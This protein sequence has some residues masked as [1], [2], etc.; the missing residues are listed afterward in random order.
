MYV[1]IGQGA[2]G[3]SAAMELR[4]L[5]RQAPVTLISAENR[6]FY[7]RIDLPDIVAG[8][9]PP[10]EALLRS[11]EQF[12]QQGVT[13]LTGQTVV[14]LLPRERRVKLACGRSLS[15]G[16]LLLALG[17]SPLLPPLPGIGAR[18]VC[19]LWT[20]EQA[21]TVLSLTADAQSAVVI[22][23]GLIGLKTAL[24]LAG[25]GM[26]TTLLERSATVMPQQLDAAGGKIIETALRQEGID[27][28]TEAVVEAL[29]SDHGRVSGVRVNGRRIAC[30]LAVVA[31]GVRPNTALARAAGLAVQSGIVVDRY[32]RS[33]QPDIYAAGDVAEV[34]GLSGTASVSATWPAAVEQ[35][36]IAARNMAGEAM[37]YP[38]YLA[39]NSVELAG[40]ALASAGDIAGGDGD[41]IDVERTASGGYRRLVFSNGRLKGFLLLGD[42]RQAGILTGAI[43]RSLQ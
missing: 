26:Q 16:K 20:L 35:G 39:M 8:K 4:R 37:A 12:R 29:E 1:V 10:Q 22:G 2:A 15:Y 18:G 43:C 25:R 17:A 9:Y 19:H 21:E 23:A 6:G 32:L 36:E 41:E 24:A 42:I 38:G 33:S 30:Q 40:I 28:I 14:R 5:N 27:V 7:S 34:P 11:E 31:A 13:C 3:A